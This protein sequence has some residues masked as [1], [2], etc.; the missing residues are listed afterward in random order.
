MQRVI[1]PHEITA[2][3][4]HH[5]TWAE[6]IAK[7][8]EKEDYGRIIITDTKIEPFEAQN[9]KLPCLLFSRCDL[10]RGQ[11]TNC[12]LRGSQFFDCHLS[13][14]KFI[15]CDLHKSEFSGSDCTRSTFL[16]CN[17]K[18]VELFDTCLEQATF[19]GCDLAGCAPPIPELQ[20]GV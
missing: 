10:S 3:F 14:T 6:R 16:A 7:G 12:D 1:N 8:Q 11:F 17:M 4:S 9:L 2:L 19:T 20:S 15:S 18:R 13:E 5:Q